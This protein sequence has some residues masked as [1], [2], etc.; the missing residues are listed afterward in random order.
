MRQ[1]RVAFVELLCRTVNVTEA[2]ENEMR[3]FGTVNA[4]IRLETGQDQRNVRRANNNDVPPW[5]EDDESSEL[6][7]VGG[8]LPYTN[9]IGMSGP[10][11]YDF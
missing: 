9:C 1:F 7:G 3:I 4:A 5:E 10:N 6:L 11:G 8:V 2:E